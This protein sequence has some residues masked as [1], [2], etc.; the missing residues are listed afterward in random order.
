LQ[1]VFKVASEQDPESLGAYVISQGQ[2]ASDVLAVMLLQKQFGMTKAN[3][4]LMRV[5]PLFETLADLNNSPA[6]LERRKL[7]S[8]HCH[9][10]MQTKLTHHLNQSLSIQYLAIYWQYQRQTR[11]YGWLQ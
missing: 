2:T 11:G 10:I 1:Q 3:G 4:K 5:V 8:F 7:M 6:Q 9:F